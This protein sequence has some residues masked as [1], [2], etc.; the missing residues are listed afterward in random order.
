MKSFK[1]SIKV[2]RDLTGQEA[3]NVVLRRLAEAKRQSSKQKQNMNK[4]LRKVISNT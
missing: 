3:E 4:K 2:T 1:K